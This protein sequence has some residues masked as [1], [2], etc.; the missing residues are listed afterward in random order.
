M[1]HQM[2]YQSAA[3]M[4]V[5]ISRT[6][7]DE[8][9]GFIGIGTGGRAFIMAV[10]IPLVACWLAQLTH[11][12]NFNIM[13]GPVINPDF[14]RPPAS[15]SDAELVKWPCQ[16]QIPGMEALDVFKRGRMDVSFISGAQMDKYGNLN[17]VCIGDYRKPKVRIVGPIAQA[18]HAAHAKRTII[19]IDHEHRNFASRV[20]FIS[21]VGHPA[22][23]T[24]RKELGLPG[25]GP[26]L[27]VTPLAIFG[28]EIQFG[29]LMLISIH[30]GASI[31]E[32]RKRT[33]CGFIEPDQI[34][35]T[36]TATETELRLIREEIDP[37]GLFLEGRLAQK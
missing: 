31:A 25:G 6:L 16:A 26:Q 28:F 12:P 15:I 20:D 4:A 2:D 3:L 19:V 9:T 10:G 36:E 24:T 13:L 23:K 14:K 17:I 11:A 29:K 1:Q 37:N 5:C 22:A 21:G 34:K 8:E 30:P 32:V 7:K 33:V 27:V 18:D 35:E